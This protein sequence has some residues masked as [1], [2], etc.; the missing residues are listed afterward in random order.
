VVIDPVLTIDGANA[1]TYLRKSVPDENYG[2]SS[3]LLLNGGYYARRPVH[4]KTIQDFFDEPAT[5]YSATL[6]LYSTTDA[7]TQTPRPVGAYAI[8]T[9]GW[10]SF[11][12]TW[13]DRLSGVRWNRPGGDFEPSPVFVNN[14]ITQAPG[15][16]SWPITDA[17]QRWLDGEPNAGILLKYV[18]EGAGS[19]VSFASSNEADA[20]L[21][22]R[23]V[24]N[25]EPLE[26]VR[27]P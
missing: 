10:N 1:D 16:R 17:A 7:S 27:A 22:P 4:G 12:A 13:N 15:W 18:D 6:R 14:D 23:I 11:Q 25:W 24:V 21:A 3:N 20:S 19:L 5:L 26:G 8:D 2:S 9:P